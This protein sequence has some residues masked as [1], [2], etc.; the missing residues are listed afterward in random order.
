M[1]KRK[2]LFVIPDGVGIRNYLYS[3]L[4]VHLHKAGFEI[5]L[6]HKLDQ[7]LIQMV[8]DRL[9]IPIRQIEFQSFPETK[10]QTFYREATAFARLKASA[11]SKNNPTI[12]TNWFRSKSGLKKKWFLGLA[13]FFGAQLKTYESVRFFESEIERHWSNTKALAYYQRILDEHQPD[14]VFITHQR[15]PGLIPLCMAA[16]TRT[17]KTISAIFSWDNIPKARLPIRTDFYA[18]WSDHMKTELL[19]FYP[20]ITADQI[21]ITG[22]PQFDFYSKEELIIP[23]KDFAERYKLD[24]SKKW[25]L[26]SGDDEMT[27]PHDPDYLQDVAEAISSEKDIQILFRQVPVT[28]PDRY[29]HVLEKYPNIV[30]IPPQWKK[31][32][33]WSNFFP[34][35]DDIQLLMNLCY[36]CETV[37]NIGSTMALD[38]AFFDKPGIFLKYDTRKDPNWTTGI[39]YQYQHFRSLKGLDAVLAVESKEEILPK[40]S[41]AINSPQAVAADRKK[42]KT[43]IVK[44]DRPAAIE[45]V[46]LIEQLIPAATPLVDANK[47]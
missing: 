31:G 39:V 17:I 41:L 45:F 32:Q 30:H 14:L 35:F 24:S 26:F 5:L 9:K 8:N 22:T 16:T 2:V 28:T 1:K 36:H 42:W 18:V 37:L 43:K 33:F 6:M 29:R 44:T 11:K 19:D 21:F 7:E 38:F 27:S 10:V 25:V 3:D 20:E 34:L 12:L 4:I 13:E 40:I 47:V 15:V 46:N 23:R